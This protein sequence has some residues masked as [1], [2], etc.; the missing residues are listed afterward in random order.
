MPEG[1]D[2]HEAWKSKGTGYKT[3][4]VLQNEVTQDS[5]VDSLAFDMRLFSKVLIH[6]KEVGGING[7]L[8]N[9]L[10]CLN[11]SQWE[12]VKSAQPINAGQ[13]K[14]ELITDPYNWVK[15]QVATQVIPL[16]GKVTAFINGKTP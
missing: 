14:V 8:Y 4:R 12:T 6:I 11:P 5:Y 16:A 1:R 15:V 7:I 9:V 10:A 2:T 13:T 3:K